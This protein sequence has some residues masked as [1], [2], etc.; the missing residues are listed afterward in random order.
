MGS[1]DAR[2]GGG[3]LGKDSWGVEVLLSSTW[4]LSVWAVLL[5]MLGEEEFGL[6]M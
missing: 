3:G 2:L 5:M 1:S 6:K 4:M